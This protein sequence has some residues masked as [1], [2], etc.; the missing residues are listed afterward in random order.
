MKTEIRPLDGIRENEANPRQ[1]QKD[2]FA[3]LVDSLLVFPKMLSIRPIVVD[4]SGVIL[5]GNMRYRALLHIATLSAN[6]IE[7]R[8]AGLSDYNDKTE[9]ERKDIML[10]WSMFLDKPAAPVI[11][12]TE[13]SD[14]DRQA[15]IIKDNVG[16]GDW[17]WDRL[18]NEWDEN[19]LQEWGLD[20][21]K[22]EKKECKED[23]YNE[24]QNKTN[25]I[26]GDLFELSCEGITH[27]LYCGDSSSKEDV[28][29]LM[30]DEKAD[31]VFSDPPYDMD[32]DKF[33]DNMF[34]VI[35]KNRHLFCMTSD[36]N[37]IKIAHKHNEYFRKLFAVDF[38]VAHLVSN[39]CP[40]TRVDI[41]AEFCNGNTY[42]HNTK[43]G[44]TTLI[45]C[46]KVHTSSASTFGHNQAKKVKLPFKFIE[47]YTEPGDL[48]VDFFAGVGSTLI[49]SQQLGRK[50]YNIE[51][52]PLYCQTILDRFKKSYPNVKINHK[53]LV[54]K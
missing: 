1:M 52:N 28:S 26:H 50:S 2:K 18:A 43:D 3:K 10:H 6:D 41:I 4:D 21:W 33:S 7:G 31:L 45:E 38:K 11:N 34:S 53:C 46:E 24:K 40:M 8:L 49:A 44:F 48:V 54:S 29:L 22:K 9:A 19:K 17:D 5:G 51:I 13:L 16:F 32:I 27:R 35:K 30:N 14:A 36:K 20:I 42:F 15:F 47:H 39:Q 12:A 37:I 23:E 25:I